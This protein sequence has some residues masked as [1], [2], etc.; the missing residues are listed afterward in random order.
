MH[1]WQ[2]AFVT[3]MKFAEVKQKIE[4]F[5]KTFFENEDDLTILETYVNLCLK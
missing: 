3:Q 2:D 5:K 1:V 4:K